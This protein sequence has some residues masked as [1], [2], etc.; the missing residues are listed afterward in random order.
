MQKTNKGINFQD[1]MGQVFSIWDTQYER[2]NKSQ[3][4]N[5]NLILDYDLDDRNSLN[6][7]SN[8]VFNLGQEQQTQLNNTI[9]NG[10]GQLDSTFTTLNNTDLDNTNLAFDLSYVHKL[11]KPGARISVNGHYTYYNGESLQDLNSNYFDAGGGFLRTFGF[12][13]DSK[14]DIKIFTGQVD[15]STPIGTASLET[16]AKVSSINSESEVNFFNFVGSS[17]TVDASLSDRFN[18]EENVFAAYFSFVKSWEKWSIKMGLRGELTD[19]QGV[20]FYFE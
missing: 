2:I 6:L 7:T 5:V 12:D 8:M 4:Q 19:A 10:L 18:Y 3:S 20:S 14:Q 15:Y 1:D 17:N 13:S 9:R 11:K 16:G